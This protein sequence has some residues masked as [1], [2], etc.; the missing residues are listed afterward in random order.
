MAVG[1]FEKMISTNRFKV[2]EMF[3]LKLFNWKEKD[4]IWSGWKHPQNIMEDPRIIAD[5]Y[6]TYN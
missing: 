5:F 2:F 3:L 4:K 1:V 6:K